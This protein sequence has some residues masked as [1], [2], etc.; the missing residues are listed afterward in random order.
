MSSFGR[1]YKH[2]VEHAPQL[3]TRNTQII[4][5]WIASGYDVEKDIVP[6]IDRCVKHGTKSIYSF[7][8]FSGSIRSEHEKR[9]KEEIKPAEYTKEELDIARAKSLRWQLNKG[10]HTTTTG[11]QDFKWLEQFELKNGRIEA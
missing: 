2:I 11:P 5:E 4:Y 9:I 3:A 8:F 7:G 10:I 6:A 1:I